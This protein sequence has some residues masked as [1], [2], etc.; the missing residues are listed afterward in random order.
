MARLHH[1][2]G[3]KGPPALRRLR[4][5]YLRR[6][7]VRANAAAVAADAAAS[8]ALLTFQNGRAQLAPFETSRELFKDARKKAFRA[9]KKRQGLKASTAAAAPATPAAPHALTVA[10]P[11]RTRSARYGKVRKAFII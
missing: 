8:R 4:F 11:I 9:T 7:I 6:L 1:L 3:A 10:A 5:R 2:W